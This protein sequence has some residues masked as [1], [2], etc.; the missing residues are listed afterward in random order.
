LAQAPNRQASV[1]TFMAQL[2]WFMVNC[3]KLK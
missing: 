3:L 1:V 2:F